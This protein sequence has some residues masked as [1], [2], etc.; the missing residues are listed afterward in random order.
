MKPVINV[1][2]IGLG[3]VGSGVY[4]ILEDNAHQIEQR[5]GAKVVVKQIAEA[6][7]D[8]P[9][10]IQ[11]DH[12]LLA[13]KVSELINNPEI[14]IVAELIGGVEPAYHYI[15]EALK[16]GKHVVTANKELIAKKGQTLLTEAGERHQDLYFEAS[17]GGGIPIIRP[18]KVCLAGNRIQEIMGIVN[19]TTNYILTRMADEGKGF[20]EILH[21]AQVNGYAE[22][23]PTND[24]DGHDAA[25]KIAILASIGF[26][27][28][29]DVSKVY[30]EGIRKISQKDI[31]YARELGYVIKLLAIAKEIDGEMQVRVH[32]TMI[33]HSHPLASVSGVYNAIYLNAN[34]VGHLM[35]YGR[36]A[37]MEAAG[38]AVVGDI[39]D[40]ARNI[41]AGSTGRIACTCFDD[42]PTL[43]MDDVRCKHYIRLSTLDQPNVI[44]GIS[45]VFG[46]ND[47]SI[48]AV[49]AKSTDENGAAESIWVTHT[50]PEISIRRS[51]EAISALPVVTEVCNWIRVE[52]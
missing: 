51:L 46:M 13:G 20:E 45:H 5:V 42:K 19:G 23:D 26:T 50:A 29:V 21:D 34:P 37:G 36:G 24:V 48:T 28:R 25:Y 1:G 31:I 16:N 40:I 43:N 8:R 33:P 32:P 12:S 4:K 22:R 7:P 39:I 35:F 6:D 47:V 30:R 41:N 52:E 38:S 27:S 14:D 2:I 15:M 10:P 17:V 49:L 11:F 18:M 3:V 9:R 44:A